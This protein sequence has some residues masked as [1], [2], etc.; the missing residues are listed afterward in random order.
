MW[1]QKHQRKLGNITYNLDVK[2]NIGNLLGMSTYV[3]YG[4]VVL[5]ISNNSIQIKHQNEKAADGS[6]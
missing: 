4:Q 2:G 3:K 5:N 1:V 6:M